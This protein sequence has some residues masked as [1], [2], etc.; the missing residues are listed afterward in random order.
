MIKRITS[1]AESP[2]EITNR[3]T[4]IKTLEE[5]TT[6]SYLLA[7][8]TGLMVS[9]GQP[10]H[11]CLQLPLCKKYRELAEVSSLK[12]EKIVGYFNELAEIIIADMK[13]AADE[14]MQS[15]VQKGRSATLIIGEDS[16]YNYIR[17]EVRCLVNE[18]SSVPP[19]NITVS[20]L[21]DCLFKQSIISF[22]AE[23]DI[24]R[25]PNDKQLFDGLAEFKES[26]ADAIDFFRTLVMPER[27]SVS[28]NVPP[29]IFTDVMFQGNILLFY[30]RGEFDKLEHLLSDE[31]RD[32]F[33][34]I[35]TQINDFIQFSINAAKIHAY[36][37]IADMLYTINAEMMTEAEKLKDYGGAV[38]FIA[39]EFKNLAESLPLH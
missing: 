5:I 29:K 31:Q 23:T 18:I 26:L 21:E 35:C 37:K 22:A 30:T 34:K 14:K 8:C 13:N 39:G 12:A 4:I 3:F 33:N 19:E 36:K 2:D 17:N 10:E 1:I 24:M 11:V 27:V 7:F 25:N 28:E 6:R 20:Y 9:R 15:V 38:R 16:H 32:T